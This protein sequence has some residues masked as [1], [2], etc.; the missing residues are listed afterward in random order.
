MCG[1]QHQAKPAASLEALLSGGG[2]GEPSPGIRGE[3]H[4]SGEDP[5]GAA[6]KNSPAYGAW[7]VQKVAT[8][9]GEAL[10]G[11]MVCETNH[12]SVEPYNRYAGKWASSRVG[13]GGGRSTDRAEWTTQPP[14]REGPLLRRCVSKQE[15]A[16]EC[17]RG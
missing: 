3:G 12:R 13:V 10:P 11:P 14:V 1:P 2:Q 8:G 7:N 17:L 6:A 9:T 16:G 15:R 5:G 4:G